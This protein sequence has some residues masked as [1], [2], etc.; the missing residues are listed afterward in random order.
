M[1]ENLGILKNREIIDILIGDKELGKFS[2]TCK[3]ISMNFSM[4]HLTGTEICNIADSLG[5]S[6]V[7]VGCSRWIYFRDLLNLCIENKKI[8]NLFTRLFSIHKFK[9][10]Q[11]GIQI[12]I[13]ERA[14]KEITQCAI[15]EINEIL[16][17]ENY[18]LVCINNKYSI[19]KVDEYDSITPDIPAIKKVD[20]AYVKHVTKQALEYVINKN[21]PGALTLSRTLLEEVFCNVIEKRGETPS[22]KGDIYKLYNQVKDLY[23]MRQN[24]NVDRNVNMLLSGLEKILKAISDMRNNASNAHGMGNG[25]IYIQKHHAHLFVNAAMVMANYIL[26]VKEN[27]FSQENLNE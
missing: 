26:D 13:I 24:E 10:K 9:S 20:N 21:F 6:I 19:Q 22:N 25:R 4:P 5:F 7:K 27:Y 14:Y 11:P 2:P 8:D 15:K 16:S 23:D 1:S 18:R 12:D 17:C 3:D